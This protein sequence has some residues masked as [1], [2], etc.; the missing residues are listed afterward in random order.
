MPRTNPFTVTIY[1][2]ALAFQQVLGSALSYSF[3]PRWLLGTGEIVT[4][5]DDPANQ[6]LGTEGARIVAQYR[7][8]VLMSG[9]VQQ[10]TGSVLRSGTITW[11]VSDDR[12]ALTFTRAWIRPDKALQAA[13]LSDLG[14]Q[15]PYGTHTDGRADGLGYYAFPASPTVYPAET[16][17]KTVIGANLARFGS[18]VLQGKIVLGTDQGRG[19]DARAA[20]M[21]PQLRFDPLQDGLLD[22]LEWANLRLRVWQDA[23]PLGTAGTVQLDVDVPTTWTQVIGT[24]GR[25]VTDGQYQQA[26]PSGTRAILGG[27]GDDAARLFYGVNDSTGLEDRFGIAIETFTDAT[28][29]TLKWPDGLDDVAQVAAYYLLRTDVLDADKAVLRTYLAQAAATALAAGLPTAGLDISLAESDG[30]HYGGNGSDGTAPGYHVGDRIAVAIENGPTITQRIT[31]CTVSFATDG[32][33]AV[34]PKV[35]EITQDPTAQLAEAVAGIAQVVG[36]LST[37]N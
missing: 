2:K 37:R 3:T 21:L 31:E 10:R 23:N 17:V 36:R 9:F 4:R 33:L 22:L 19:G 12:Y 13:T 20:G 1:S 27:P 11:D 18:N 34:A 6:L 8:E 32:G 5:V 26:I 15:A 28:G 35:G 14:Q 25:I 7:G 24:A 30:F 29:A 16:A